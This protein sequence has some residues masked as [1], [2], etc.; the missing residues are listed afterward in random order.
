MQPKQT[1]M[2]P[3]AWQS[4]KNAALPPPRKN[5]T[6]PKSLSK[7]E[8]KKMQDAMQF[9]IYTK[10]HEEEQKKI[11]QVDTII[12]QEAQA[13]EL[14]KKDLLSQNDKLKQRLA[15][16]KR[17]ERENSSTRDDTESVRS[18]Q[19]YIQ[20]KQ[21]SGCI[22]LVAVHQPVLVQSGSVENPQTKVFKPMLVLSTTNSNSQKFNF[23]T[24]DTTSL[25]K[26][27]TSQG[28]S[29][30]TRI[31]LTISKVMS[32]QH[33]LSHSDEDITELNT[34]ISEVNQIDN[35]TLKHSIV[36]KIFKLLSDSGVKESLA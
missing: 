32:S 31:C 28:G 5:L 35:L 4:S 29:L 27:T 36:N 3:L 7:I 24:D 13:S 34:L 26:S 9:N 11:D 30:A 20:G 14:L 22:S 10:Q 6:T 16:R 25:N 23:S 8:V 2:N 15:E 33:Q 1:S 17:K 12:Q 18:Q 21:S 19:Q